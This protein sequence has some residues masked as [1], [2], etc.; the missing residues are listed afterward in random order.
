[1][2]DSET[3]LSRSTVISIPVLSW[4]QYTG[5]EPLRIRAINTRLALKN[6]GLS[7]THQDEIAD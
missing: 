6:L 4:Y 1:V 2:E 5:A 3:N 7:L